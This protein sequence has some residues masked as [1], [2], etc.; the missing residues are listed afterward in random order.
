MLERQSEV[1]EVSPAR[2]A[3]VQGGLGTS[4]ED[5]AV[6]HPPPAE[7]ETPALLVESTGQGPPREVTASL[8]WDSWGLLL[9][10]RELA[11]SRKFT[12]IAY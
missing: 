2:R 8:R 4:E 3:P 5:T 11:Y 9:P 6:T 1:G 10:E 7:P 12:H